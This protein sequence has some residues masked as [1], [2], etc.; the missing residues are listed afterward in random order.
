MRLS[1]LVKG[2]D[3][4][5]PSG[6]DKEYKAIIEAAKQ[7][8]GMVKVTVEPNFKQRSSKCN[9]YF[10]VLCGMLSEMSGAT[11]EQVK[12]MAKTKA[13]ALGYPILLDED[14]VMVTNEYGFAGIPS[15]QSTDAQCALLCEAVHMI[16]GEYGYYLED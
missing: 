10:H 3:F 12:E 4:R 5:V 11:K 16:A 2:G 15:S 8:D 9:A 14:E 6:F 1:F 7:N 13:V